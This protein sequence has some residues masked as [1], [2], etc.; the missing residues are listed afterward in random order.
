MKRNKK[1]KLKKGIN[2]TSFVS[3]NGVIK[4]IQNE[5]EK[6]K[7]GSIVKLLNKL[8]ESS[9]EAIWVKVMAKDGDLLTGEVVEKSRTKIDSHS[10][11]I[12]TFQSNQIWGIRENIAPTNNGFDRQIYRNQINHEQINKDIKGTELEKE[13]KIEEA[14]K[15]YEDNV[16]KNHAFSHP[17]KRLAIIYRKQGRIDDEIR[18]LKKAM[19]VFENIVYKKRG[20][21]LPSLEGFKIRLEKATVI[22]NKQK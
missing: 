11:E 5:I 3:G 22:K 2:N 10:I 20:D 7:P 21:W 15:L 12:I 18:V 6:I 4:T 17:Y 19:W 13:N 9:D 14:I 8:D 16:E 1:D